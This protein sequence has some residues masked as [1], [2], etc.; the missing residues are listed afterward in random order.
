MNE[1]KQARKV[2]ELTLIQLAD[3]TGLTIANLSLI[4]RGLSKPNG[5]TIEKLEKV[6]GTI[7]WLSNSKGVEKGECV[8]KNEITDLIR[9]LFSVLRNSPD[10]EQK[11]HKLIITKHLERL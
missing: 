4:E 5:N 1:L 9:K 7:D 11:Q 8:S 2:K 6:L 3:K 10:E